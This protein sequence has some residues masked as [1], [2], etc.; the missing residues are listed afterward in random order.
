VRTTRPCLVHARAVQFRRVTP[1]HVFSCP[2]IETDLPWTC[3]TAAS[4]AASRAFFRLSHYHSKPTI[5]AASVGVAAG[6]SPQFP[7]SVA[8][9]IPDTGSNPTGSTAPDDPGHQ[10]A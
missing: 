2:Q 3:L 7:L 4:S 1:S 5:F 6:F 9:A 8:A 10:P